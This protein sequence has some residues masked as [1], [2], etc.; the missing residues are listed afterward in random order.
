[1]VPEDTTDKIDDKRLRKVQQV[2]GGVLYYTHAVDCTVLTALSSIASEQ[3]C[4]TEATEEKVTQ[5]LDY[6]AL[7]PNTTIQFHESK[8]ILNVHSDASYLSEP[9]AKS[10]VAGHYFLGKIPKDGRP[11]M[12]NGNIFVMCGILKFVVCLAADAELEV[13]FLNAKARKIIWLI[14]E[15]LVHPQPPTPVHCANQTETGID[16]AP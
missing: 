1:M 2:I 10:R 12:T 8:M 16:C 7:K 5:L 13:L 6:L 14:L 15:E 3:A 11:I 9:N 4:L